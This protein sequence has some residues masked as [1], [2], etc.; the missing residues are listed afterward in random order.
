MIAQADGDPGPRRLG[1]AGFPA[2]DR[3]SGT[4]LAR[5]GAITRGAR[6]GRYAGAAPAR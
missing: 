6:A 4:A 1:A 2:T 3:M 5:V